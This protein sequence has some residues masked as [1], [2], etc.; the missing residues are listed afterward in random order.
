MTDN[1]LENIIGDLLRVG[2]LLAVTIVAA[3]GSLYLIRHHADITL[4]SRFRGTD[5]SLRTVGGIWRAAIQLDSDA[6]IQL[7]LLVLIATPIARVALAAV[8]F[9][10]EHDRLYVAVSLI[11]LAILTYS[12][13]HAV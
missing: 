13:L 1:K 7:G 5:S 11:V 10:L 9:Y 8:G 3:G 6:L 12:I 2:V 4:Y